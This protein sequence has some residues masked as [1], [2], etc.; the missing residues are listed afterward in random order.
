MLSFSRKVSLGCLWVTL[1]IARRYS[2]NPITAASQFAV[3]DPLNPAIIRLSG[4][5]PC[6]HLKSTWIFAFAKLNHK[7]LQISTMDSNI[8]INWFESFL[9]A[10][11]L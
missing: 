10:V 6:D 3:S 2:D 11:N 1:I 8:N 5:R 7:F 9:L 4:K